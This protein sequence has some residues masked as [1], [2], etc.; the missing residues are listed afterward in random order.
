MVYKIIIILFIYLKE[1]III[2]IIII[3]VDNNDKKSDLD[4]SNV[5]EGHVQKLHFLN[6]L[7]Y[8][9]CAIAYNF[10]PRAEKLS[11]FLTLSKRLLL[12]F[13]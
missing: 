2:I 6:L 7:L 10:R 12:K 13:D 5:F 3:K 9:V 4:T 1:N 8:I 11:L